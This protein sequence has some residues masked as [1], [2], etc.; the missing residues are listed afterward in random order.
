MTMGSNAHLR[1]RPGITRS[2]FQ[3]FFG[4][5]HPAA[6][7]ALFRRNPSGWRARLLAFFLLWAV[8]AAAQQWEPVGPHQP[9]DEERR[10]YAGREKAA[11]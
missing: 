7:T 8:P 6:P 10:H 9:V 1:T 11:R 3:Y 5:R 4:R 2:A